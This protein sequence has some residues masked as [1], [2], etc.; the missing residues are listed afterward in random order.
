MQLMNKA[1]AGG[2]AAVIVYAGLFATPFIFSGRILPGVV[3]GDVSLTG[4]PHAA[5]GG[6]IA[7]YE[8]ELGQQQVALVLREKKV[9]RTL[10]ALGVTVD[11]GMTLTNLATTHKKWQ[12]LLRQPV[13]PVVQLT[14]SDI[15]AVA[16]Q[17]FSSIIT[18]PT[19]ATL[20]VSPSNTLIVTPSA[21][22]ESIDLTT[23]RED[24]TSRARGG[25]WQS[26]IELVV[27]SAPPS[28]HEG[29]IEAARAFATT[30][31]R[32][33]MP[34]TDGETTWTI[35]PFTLSRLLR[36]TPIPDP[37]R[38][39]NEVL[40]VTVDAV[41]AADYF[42]TT[43]APEINQPAVDARF[44]RVE[45]HVTQFAIPQPGKALNVD[46]S[47][48]VLQGALMAGQSS[49]ALSVDSI[50]PAIRDTADIEA[51]GLTHLL[52]TGTSDFAGSPAN[53]IHNI[54]EGTKRYH[55]LL[56]PAGQEFSFNEFLGP[57]DGAHG[58]KPEL[59]IKKNVTIPEFGGG[60]C[61]VSTTLFRAAV[62]A[63]LDITAR[64]NHAYAVRYYGTPGFDATIYPPYTDLR[65]TN[66]TP[67][68]ILI[69][70][71]VE[72]TELAFE[73]WGT[74]D[75]REVVVEGPQ[76]YGR[77]KDGAVKATVTQKVTKNGEVVID[78]T[79]YSNYRSPNLFPKVLGN[80]TP[81]P[82]TTPPPPVSGPTPP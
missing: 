34:V 68:Y 70:T 29:E 18:L 82:T 65:F 1:V 15:S 38:A 27:V 67:G 39:D 26:P 44:E 64:R 25:F 22:G 59:V 37:A 8:R 52:A 78:D 69:Q 55:G 63:G 7:Q 17:E 71:R 45:D 53:R 42:T 28:V 50:D 58:F 41:G 76:T 33:G 57:V 3:L 23:L 81:S 79:F 74:N 51:M 75:G 40:G 54:L 72:G 9:E 31:L 4:V 77:T 62:H 5:L 12:P 35:K 21:V 49:A 47:V 16:A 32:E 66:N 30:L 60:L 48:T 36:F 46:Q 24:I 14:Q 19:N 56:V 2:V 11:P 61:Q 6:V 20:T 73:L 80:A 13:N 10:S 43:L